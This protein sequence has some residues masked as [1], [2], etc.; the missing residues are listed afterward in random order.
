VFQA[1][2]KTKVGFIEPMYASEARE[3][4]EEAEW[5]YEAKLDGY[6]CLAGKNTGVT[7]WSRRGTLFNLRFPEVAK[8]CEKL[9]ADTVI[10]GEVVAIDENGRASFNTL[11]HSR[12]NRHLQFYAFDM[13]IYRGRSLLNVPLETRRDLLERA[14]EK[15]EYPVLF[16]RTFDAKPAALIEA[17]KELGL[18]GIIAK[19]KGSLYVPGRRTNAWAKYKV[20]QSQE[21]VIGGYTPGNPFDSLIVG[22]YDGPKLLFVGK[23]RN[24]FVPHVRRE[25]YQR[26]KPM[27]SDT[28]PFGNLPEKRRTVWALTAEEMKNCRW[29][30][31]ELIAQIDF[32]EWTPDSH[33]RHPSFAGLRD[34]KDPRAVTLDS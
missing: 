22:Y 4:P 29:L 18:E 5:A 21:F 27:E 19:R 34:D 14:L 9:P 26:I 31:P 33:L 20:N 17:A 3:L 13:P 25:V 1:L 16:S 12:K 23:V 30:K 6:R 15:V 32:R 10:D 7:L 2:P 11:Q 24:G 28:C 8:A